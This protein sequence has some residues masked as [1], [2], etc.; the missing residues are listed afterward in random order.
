MLS[1]FSLTWDREAKGLSMRHDTN[2]SNRLLLRFVASDCA[3]DIRTR[4]VRGILGVALSHLVSFREVPLGKHQPDGGSS[5]GRDR[6]DPRPAP[7]G[8][9]RRPSRFRR[10]VRPPS[11][12][13]A[14]RDHPE[15]RGDAARRI[16]PSD[17]VQDVQIDA[18]NRLTEYLGRR[19]MP[20]RLWLFRSAIERVSKLRRHAVAARR[21]IGRERPLSLWDSSSPSPARPVRSAGPTPS[22]QAAAHD[23]AS[24]LHAALERL[25]EPDRA[26]LNIR[27][28]EGLSYEE[29][30]S[31]LGIDPAAARKRYG[32]ALLRLRTLLL[33]EG[34]TESHLWTNT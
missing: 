34:L 6:R 4:A 21:D 23:A 14:P 29:A 22:Q 17:V 31:R 20:F 8:R 9:G 33:A 24:R 32:R 2:R 3:Q 13:L 25:A 10:V 30:G 16:D 19:P 7:A 27:A 15:A 11:C 26:L 12:G 1:S 5:F 28:F 18:L